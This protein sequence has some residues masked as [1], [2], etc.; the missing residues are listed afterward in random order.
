MASSPFPFDHRDEPISAVVAD[1]VVEIQQ[2]VAQWLRDVGCVVTCVSTGR[3]AV[4]VLRSTH[5]DIVV[6]D[7]LMPE[8]DGLEVI[9]ELRKAQ[10]STR[11]LAISGGG[12]HLRADDCLKFARGL[13]AHGLL[14]KPFNRQQF[15]DALGLILPTQGTPKTA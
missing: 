13:G 14:M 10:A 6:T 7:V 15:L 12:N 9:S 4:R 5:V 1:D 3:E 8:G 2:L 11:V